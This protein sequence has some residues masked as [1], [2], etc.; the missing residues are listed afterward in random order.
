[1]IEDTRSTC[2]GGGRD[3]D[4]RYRFAFLVLT[5][6]AMPA[7]LLCLVLALPFIAGARYQPPSMGETENDI[8]ARL[9]EPFHDTRGDFDQFADEREFAYRATWIAPNGKR[10]TVSFDDHQVAQQV[11][12]YSR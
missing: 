10:Y 2:Q 8:R 9:G 12:T 11:E 7:V 1:M 3:P 5:L 4:G 6:A